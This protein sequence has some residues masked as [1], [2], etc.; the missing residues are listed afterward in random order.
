MREILSML[1][2]DTSRQMPLIEAAIGEGDY[3]RARRLAHYSK[4]ACASAGA[5]AA[6]A[7]L[8]DLEG[9]AARS[10]YAE[11]S[12]SL[13]RLANELERLRTEAAMPWS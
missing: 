12:A 4:G 10:E 5:T 2:D 3:T 11:C 6:A 13:R 8:A 9:R 7:A 1:I